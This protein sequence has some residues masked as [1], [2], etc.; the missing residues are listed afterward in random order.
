M[1]LHGR[2]EKL[3]PEEGGFWKPVIVKDWSELSQA[4]AAWRNWGAKAYKQ[5]DLNHYHVDE[6]LRAHREG[7]APRPERGRVEDPTAECL[8]HSGERVLDGNG[9]ALRVE[10]RAH[11]KPK[12]D[13]YGSKTPPAVLRSVMDF[14]YRLHS[15]VDWVDCI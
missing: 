2:W 13:W 5:K 8:L 6:L 1:H 12:K 10:V 14:G 9:N 15:G 4:Q 11:H 3:S 7:R